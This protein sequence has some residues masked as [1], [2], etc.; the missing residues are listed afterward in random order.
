MK[1]LLN[2][3]A[4]SVLTLSATVSYAEPQKN[5]ILFILADDLGYNG[6]H[7]Y[8]NPWLETPNIDKLAQDGMKFTNGLA[9]YP[10]CQPSRMA[11][12]SGQYGPRTSGYRVSN[13]HRGK[14]QFIK[15]IVPEKHFLELNKI[16]IA[17]AFKKAGYATAMF[18]KWHVGNLNSTHPLHQGFDEAI[19]A[20]GHYHL[21]NSA[22]KFEL[23]HGSCSEE[24]LTRKAE[25]FIKKCVA[26]KKTFFLYMPYYFVHA[27]F[28]A[29]PKLVA[30]FKNKLKDK[31]FIGNRPQIVPIVAAMT[32]QLDS[33]IGKLIDLL[34]KL[35]IRKNTII[36]FTS[37]NG[38]Y[39]LNFTGPLRGKKGDTYEGGMRVPYI[40]VWD[41][42]IKPASV[43]DERIMGIDIYPTL[44]S[45]ANVKPPD[46]Y[47][48]DGLD[49][50]PILLGGKQALPKRS[51][52]CFYPKYAQFK[53]RL[54]RWRLSWR[55]VVYYDCF[56]LIEY[57]EYNE[58]E[59]FDLDQ[60]PKENNNIF[61]AI[62]KNAEQL[63][64]ILHS[65]LEN[66]NAPKL[67]PNPNYTPIIPKKPN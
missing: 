59:L 46:N 61:S 28:E 64:N 53:K 33:Y 58:Y 4:C 35:K 41:G 10:T 3:S 47:T 55:N 39:D 60:D 49:I 25:N 14:E 36:I 63:K 38:S 50:S 1:T 29:D 51:L 31:H 48:L 24:I 67:I 57:P 6:L 62:P 42:K 2:I 52:F 22:P 40:F 9:A 37:D 66:I 27:P 20:T 15:Y 7:C 19:V 65:W 21:K 11:I 43:S 18:G 34:T 56:K 30:Y 17:E 54:G 32:K 12:L 26:E 13:P 16:T 45:L 8:G 23:P 5:N 44:L